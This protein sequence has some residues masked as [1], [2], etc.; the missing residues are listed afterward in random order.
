MRADALPVLKR[1]EAVRRVFGSNEGQF[2]LA[3]LSGLA[4]DDVISRPAQAADLTF[5]LDANG[6][7]L[8]QWLRE[9]AYREQDSLPLLQFTLNELY[10]HRSGRELTF[11]AYQQLGGLAGSI[12]ITAE[13]ILKAEVAGSAHA[14]RRLFRNL[15]SVDET[16]HA[17]RR[18]VPWVEV[19]QEA[20]LGRLLRQ[21]VAAR[22]CVTDQR[23]G[24]SVVAFAHDSLLRTLPLLID[25]LRGE[26]G[27]LQT[28]ELA[29]REAR[30]WQHHQLSDAWLAG[31]DKLIAFEAL[32]AAEVALSPLVRTFIER[33]RR[34]VRRTSR[35][36][37]TAVALIAV[38]AIAA[39]IG[40]W[41]ATQKQREAE[42][43][44]AQAR[45]AQLQLLTEAA[46]ER[47]KDGD[48]AYARGVI[49]EVLRHRPSASQPDPAAVNVFQEI[50]ANDPALAILV[51]HDEPVRRAE[52]SP[53]GQQ[54][55]TAA[56]DGTARIWDA[57]TGIQL[58]ILADHG[59]RSV[60]TAVYSPDGTRI[61]TASSD[62]T[63]RIWEASTGRELAVLRDVDRVTCAV[64]SP[65]GSQ[66]ATLSPKSLRLWDARTGAQLRAFSLPGVSFGT[67]N[68]DAGYRGSAAYSPDGQRIVTTM[69]DRTARIW[70]VRTGSVLTVLAGHTE[71]VATAAYSPDGKRIVTSGDN[72]AR[73]WD[74]A[75]GQQLLVLAGHERNVWSA[76][77]SPDRTMIAT[78]S[79]DKT[80]RIW[81]ATSGAQLSVLSGHVDILCAAAFSP[82]GRHLV[83]AA[84]D[85][86]AR[87]WNLRPGANATVLAGHVDQVASVAYSPDG[88]Y[89][90]TTGADKTARLWDSH[91]HA[92]L[93]VLHDD[94]N[95]FNSARFSPDGLHII[96][97]S[98]DNSARIWDVQTRMPATVL[99]GPAPVLSVAYSADGQRIVGTFRNLTFGVWDAH[100][101]VLGEVRLGHRDTVATAVFSP[102][103]KQILTASVDKTVR[104]WDSK[105]LS[106]LTTLSH[107]DFVNTAVYSADGTRIVSA[108][109]DSTARIWDART[110]EQ[111]GVLSGHHSF[112]YSAAF[113]PDGSRI[114]TGSKDKTVRI[115]DARTGTQLAVLMGHVAKVNEVAYSPDGTRIASA[116]ADKTVRIWDAHIP[117]A[118]PAQV[119]WEEAAEADA[120]SGVERTHLG[121]APTTALLADTTI[122]SYAQPTRQANSPRH[123]TTTACDRQAAAYY[124]PDRHTQGVEQDRIDPDMAIQACAP[125]AASDRA[126]AQALY[127][128][129]RALVA[130]VDFLGA[131]NKFER[132]I[133][134]GSR[135]ARIDLALLLTNTEAKMLDPP[136]AKALY[137][138]AWRQNIL[139]GGFKLGE[140]YEQGIS[141]ADHSMAFPRDPTQARLWYQRAAAAGQPHALARLA[142]WGETAALNALAKDGKATLLLLE[143]FRQYAQAAKIASAEDWPDRV[144]RAWRYRRSTLARVLAEEGRMEQVADTYQAV[145]DHAVP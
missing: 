91:T 34:H 50:R 16:G 15:V 111:T 30:L 132:A 99:N 131:R 142:Q 5:G 43:Q 125:L 63:A 75:T 133:S 27:L 74:A 104:M 121:L 101:G 117:A 103:K 72:T 52:Y 113:S 60:N 49:L 18:Y 3:T 138:Q 136:R 23:E 76:V 4:L 37:Q 53:D 17:T 14:A 92:Q 122:Q 46:A 93:A 40:A 137:Q 90:V 114:V 82:D 45:K 79:T 22:L 97:A 51:G 47:L 36:K 119:L 86:T 140:L 10:L 57:R 109:D 9:E 84:W 85:R 44:T 7:R 55:L 141:A 98:D 77:Y 102:D 66:I 70:D 20:V 56:M 144:W 8:D 54:I 100:T 120:L 80:I 95:T 31:S 33:S 115:W 28:R 26:A 6:K 107:K 58:R 83:T 71:Y 62:Q 129:G 21:L 128:A 118:F 11:A 116:S 145:R 19:T 123:D 134:L 126:S 2:Y 24:E 143:A 78:A 64:Y 67:P 105:T 94:H 41:I 42:Y 69:E 29:Q 48:I 88:A 73:I 32:T 127:Q 35:I 110:G 135:A 106:P 61:V 39:S 81:D 87:T 96:T 1:H 139:F 89:L 68:G 130:K 124:D 12:A 108:V 65:D 38:L 59:G 25:W 112:V 13:S